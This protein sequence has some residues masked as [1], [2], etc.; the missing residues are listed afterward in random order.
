MSIKELLVS[1]QNFLGVSATS[2]LDAELIL[3]HVL[4][5]ERE[6]LLAH[7]EENVETVFADLFNK[8]LQRVKQG[9]PIAYI[10]NEK[11]FFGLN[12]YVD[13][14]VL[15]PRPETEQ[16]VKITCDF[17]TEAVERG[18]RGIRILDIGTGSGNIPVAIAKVFEG[19]DFNLSIDAL[20]I[21]EDALEVA[22]INVEQYSLTERINLFQSDLL[23][24]IEDGEHFDLIL[25]N[26]PYIATDNEKKFLAK[27]VEDHEPGAALF[28]G[29][30]GLDL[31]K[32]LFQQLAEKGVSFDL[33]IGE[34]GFGQTKILTPV[35]DKYFA[36]D[37]E[38][39]EDEAGIDR[40]FQIRA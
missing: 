18:K 1:G 16:L 5:V 38:I 22:R 4:G 9:E 24:V 13:N 37:Y 27:N 8:Y 21:S 17:I 40:F 6:Y 34:F 3:A 35:L 12:F 14:R 20:D 32:K 2:G 19:Y 29:S 11:E 10:T 30:D 26:L 25:A 39:I 36:Q 7:S 23:E 31:Y 28:A 33:L 15:L